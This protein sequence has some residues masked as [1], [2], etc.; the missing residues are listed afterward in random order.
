LAQ[1][2]GRGLAAAVVHLPG[3]AFDLDKPQD[4]RDWLRY[5]EKTTRS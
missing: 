1:I 2:A 4:L 3:L 5:G